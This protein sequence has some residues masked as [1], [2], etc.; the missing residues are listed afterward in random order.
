VQ[1]KF[2]FFAVQAVV[3]GC[4]L[5]FCQTLYTGYKIKRKLLELLHKTA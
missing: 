5:V 2:V 4:Q 3:E 1:K